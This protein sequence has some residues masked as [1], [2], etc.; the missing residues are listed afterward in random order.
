MG[1]FSSLHGA[2]KYLKSQKCLAYRTGSGAVCH[3]G[4]LTE[5]SMV[6]AILQ[7]KLASSIVKHFPTSFDLFNSK[8]SIMKSV[9]I[10]STYPCSKNRC[11]LILSTVTPHFTWKCLW[12]FKCMHIHFLFSDGC[13]WTLHIAHLVSVQ[14]AWWRRKKKRKGCTLHPLATPPSPMLWQFE[15]ENPSTLLTSTHER[16]PV[17]APTEENGPCPLIYCLS[18]E[19]G[20][21]MHLEL[22]R[23]SE[24][25]LF[26]LWILYYFSPKNKTKQKNNLFPCPF[27]VIWLW[28]AHADFF[29][30]ES[31]NG[32]G[33]FALYNFCNSLVNFLIPSI[34][35]K[36]IVIRLPTSILSHLL[37]LWPRWKFI[38]IPCR[39]K[40]EW[41]FF[42]LA[43]KYF[44]I[45]NL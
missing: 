12:G 14:F 32:W 21:L 22:T 37:W 28:H 19:E 10:C 15:A 11:H 33:H 40:P 39:L 18:Q 20:L 45:S 42:Q 43:A 4:V 41:M 9:I 34:K 16:I 38:I 44:C 23:C 29:P 5:L 26:A 35:S 24:T 30:C 31:K 6:T 3:M 17:K 1:L 13:Q 36:H 2:L 8:I 7:L 27:P 25:H